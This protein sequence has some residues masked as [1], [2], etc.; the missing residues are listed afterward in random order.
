MYS[1]RTT[2]KYSCPAMRHAAGVERSH[3]MIFYGVFH[4]HGGPPS[5]L[6]MVQFME[7]PEMDDD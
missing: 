5:E 2:C 7:N 3:G 1:V 4:G 6:R